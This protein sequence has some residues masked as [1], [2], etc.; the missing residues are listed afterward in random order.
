MGPYLHLKGSE[1][2]APVLSVVYN[3]VRFNEDSELRAPTRGPKDLLWSKGLPKKNR[4]T[5]LGP[6]QKVV[7]MNQGS[8]LSQMGSNWRLR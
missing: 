5:C 7:S 2:Y 6:L 1:L 4:Q 8:F 3:G